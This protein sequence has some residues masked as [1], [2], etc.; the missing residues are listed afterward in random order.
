MRMLLFFF[1]FMVCHATSTWN[2]ED[3]WWQWEKSLKEPRAC[4]CSGGWWPP[5]FFRVGRVGRGGGVGWLGNCGEGRIIRLIFCQ[6]HWPPIIIFI[7]IIIIILYFHILYYYYLYPCWLLLCPE[8]R[9]EAEQRGRGRESAE[10]RAERERGERVAK[11]SWVQCMRS[12]AE[13]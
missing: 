7:I 10:K 4:A 12:E 9:G 8:C 11:C 2:K 5:L 3:R 6:C 13:R 1:F